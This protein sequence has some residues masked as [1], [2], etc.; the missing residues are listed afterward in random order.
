MSKLGSLGLID[1]EGAP[2]GKP[3]G[4]PEMHGAKLGWIDRLWAKLGDILLRGLLLCWAKAVGKVLGKVEL[5][6]TG[7]WALL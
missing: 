7:L 6:G 2:L 5:V 1:T 4:Q 3:L